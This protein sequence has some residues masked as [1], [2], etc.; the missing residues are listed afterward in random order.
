MIQ[1][2]K[3]QSKRA[4]MVSIEGRIFSNNIKV[5]AYKETV[6][7]IHKISYISSSYLKA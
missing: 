4:R 6:A 1:Y 3:S 5:N 2:I 7:N